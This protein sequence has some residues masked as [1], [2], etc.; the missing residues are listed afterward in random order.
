MLKQNIAN[1]IL[2]NLAH[3]GIKPEADVNSNL[4]S[5]VV[6]GWNRQIYIIPDQPIK[7]H[8]STNKKITLM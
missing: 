6:E 2:Y 3:A 8:K 1:F 5:D 7:I 4:I